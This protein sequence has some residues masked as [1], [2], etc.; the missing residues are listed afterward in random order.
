MTSLKYRYFYLKCRQ[1]SI[2]TPL[3]SCKTH[4]KAL[5]NAVLTSISNLQSIAIQVKIS[6]GQKYLIFPE[7]GWVI[8]PIHLVMALQ[9]GCPGARKIRGPLFSV[10]KKGS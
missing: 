7:V 5:N 1:F 8:G 6:I 10:L 9:K 4:F 2:R 3:C